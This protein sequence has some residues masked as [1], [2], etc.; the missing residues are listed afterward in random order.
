M[1]ATRR[2]KVVKLEDVVKTAKG[3]GAAKVAAI[4]AKVQIKRKPK[5]AQTVPKGKPKSGRVEGR[6]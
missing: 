5:T 1:V 2:N 3:V 4:P 6:T